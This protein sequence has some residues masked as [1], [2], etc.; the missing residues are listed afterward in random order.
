MPNTMAVQ[1]AYAGLFKDESDT[2]DGFPWGESVFSVSKGF[3][4][5]L[6]G[7]LYIVYMCAALAFF[8]SLLP[9]AA[10]V[11]GVL[12][13]GANADEFGTVFYSYA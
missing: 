2:Y 8:I 1:L 11:L 10:H 12:I 7:F 5:G 3:L 4:S 9:L 13:R 6:Q